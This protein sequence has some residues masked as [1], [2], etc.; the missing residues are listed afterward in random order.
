MIEDADRYLDAFVDAGADWVSLHVEVV[1]HLERTV[2]HL[3]QARA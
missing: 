3:R 2:A 1:P